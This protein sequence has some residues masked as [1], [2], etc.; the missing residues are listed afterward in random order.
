MEQFQF[1]WEKQTAES[2]LSTLRKCAF[3][4]E[5]VTSTM[6]GE[7]TRLTITVTFSE[8]KKIPEKNGQT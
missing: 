1:S 7:N 5:V 8:P 2:L 4:R 3:C 6:P